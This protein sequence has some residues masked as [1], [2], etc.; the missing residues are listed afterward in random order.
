MSMTP[1]RWPFKW[2]LLGSIFP[3]TLFVM[4]YKVV[5]A[6]E[7]EFLK[8]D[9]SNKSYWTV[10]SC[11]SIYYAVQGGSNVWIRGWNPTC[12]PFKWTYWAVTFMCIVVTLESVNEILMSDYLNGIYREEISWSRY[13]LLFCVFNVSDCRL[14]PYL[15]VW[16]FRW[17]AGVQWFLWM[18]LSCGTR[19]FKVWDFLLS[20]FPKLLGLGNFSVRN[21]GN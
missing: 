12:W 14:N 19:C 11:D 15:N 1:S 17:K 20:C 5:L 2:K 8:R 16:P 3:V 9:H 21:N 10:L 7:Y 13:R 18:V 6:F 4:L